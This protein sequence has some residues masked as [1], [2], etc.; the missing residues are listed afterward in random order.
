[1]IFHQS[2]AMNQETILLSDVY[3][4]VRMLLTKPSQENSS[5]IFDVISGVKTTLLSRKHVPCYQEN[6]YPAIKRTCTLLSR[7]HVPCYQENMYPAIKR[8]CT[9]LSR[10][11]VPCYQENMYP[12]I[13]RTCSLLSREHVPCYQ[14][15]MY[16]GIKG[17]CNLLSREHVPYYQ[18][19]RKQQQLVN[20]AHNG[21]IE[22]NKL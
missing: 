8:T 12:A 11:H 17:T 20:L 10:E 21:G 9:L 22:T 18:F 16:P 2:N 19:P 15:N 3:T 1:M 13:K 6:M 5:I 14:E 4:A 7:E